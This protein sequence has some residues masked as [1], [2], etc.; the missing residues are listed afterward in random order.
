MTPGGTGSERPVPVL[1]SLG[2]NLG[3]RLGHL[4]RGVEGLTR[5]VEIEAVS[6]IYESPPAGYEA[7]P[8]F[9]NAVVRGRTVF[10]PREL[11]ALAQEVEEEEG[12]RRSFPNAP[13]TL[14][15]DI[16]FFGDRVMREAGLILPHPRWR[17]RAFVR[18]PL[19]EVA[20]DWKDP[21]SGRILT[22]GGRAAATRHGLRRVAPGSRLVPEGGLRGV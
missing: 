3:D 4:R 15:I 11:L 6:S 1:L 19:A 2:S 17:E 18:V 14:D 20:G 21:E 8:D 12:R 22:A 9:L 10:G 5:G 16:L 13:R 7:Q